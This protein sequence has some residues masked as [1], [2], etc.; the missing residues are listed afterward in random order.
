MSISAFIQRCDA[1]TAEAGIS[2]ATLSNKLFN[3]S[4]KIDD[5][6]NEKVDVGVRKLERV[7]AT[8]D[9]LFR[10]LNPPSTADP[11]AQAAPV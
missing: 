6:A 9:G 4:R 10:D 11:P 2:R 7:Q 8:L 5:L 3:D 1:Y